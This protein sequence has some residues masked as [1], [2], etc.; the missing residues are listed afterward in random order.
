[1]EKLPKNTTAVVTGA[2]SGI[3]FALTKHLVEAGAHV[4]GVG[5]S[6]RRNLSAK[7]KILSEIYDGQLDYLNADLAKPQMIRDLAQNVKNYL[8][9]KGFSKLDILVN[10]AG[11]YLES[12]EK[13][14][15]GIEKTFAV[16]HLAQFRLTY[17]LQS[18]LANSSR[19]IMISVSS[20]AH[21]NTPMNLKR[22][23]DPR[24]YIG[25]LA[26]KRSKL[27]NVLFV[28]ELRKKF[29]GFTAYA[30]DPGLVNTRIGSKSGKGISD[31][32]WSYR[33]KNGMTPEKSA[34]DLFYIITKEDLD[35]SD[36][37][38]FKERKAIQPS[39]NAR[40]DQLAKRLWDLSCELTG[41]E[42]R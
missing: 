31:F 36:G 5:R 23:A 16:N 35:P 2:T 21:F 40:N 22:I 15:E 30:I 34:K 4:I 17:Y 27:C 1:M 10:N 14:I 20:Y 32:V 33:R 38:Y 9:G 24:P 7:E 12:K 39:K 18:F 11:V 13:T 29:L 28:R 42:W 37:I 3:G 26:Y 41:L 25:L 19:G 6:D 8:D